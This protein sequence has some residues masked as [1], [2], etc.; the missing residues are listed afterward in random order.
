MN[1]KDDS[2]LWVFCEL[3]MAQPIAYVDELSLSLSLPVD[4]RPN[5][6]WGQGAL[7]HTFRKSTTDHFLR[8]P[9]NRYPA[10]YCAFEGRV[11]SRPFVVAPK[12][13][14]RVHGQRTLSS[15]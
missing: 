14:R 7:L 8:H 11:A 9:A 13:L 1:V 12:L 5:N 6:C 10:Y 4:C 15:F 2:F 3:I